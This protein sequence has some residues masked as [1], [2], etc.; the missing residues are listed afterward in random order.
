MDIRRCRGHAARMLVLVRWWM[1]AAGRNPAALNKQS[2]GREC[3]AYLLFVPRVAAGG[4]AIALDLTQD[5]PYL[6]RWITGV[7]SDSGLVLQRS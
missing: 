1:G 2:S 6:S 3:H 4:P 5:K 7:R